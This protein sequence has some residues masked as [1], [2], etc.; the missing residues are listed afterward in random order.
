[1]KS[2]FLTLATP[3][4]V[5]LARAVLLRTAMPSDPSKPSPPLSRADL[6]IEA[7]LVVG[8]IRKPG[9]ALKVME[10]LLSQDEPV[11]LLRPAA[12]PIDEAEVRAEAIVWLREA[13]VRARAR[14]AQ[15]HAL[16]GERRKRRP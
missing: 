3:W 15:R 12:S 14:A 16:K 13:S 6:I 5:T 2:P 4:A 9:Y 8:E 7:M 11:A 1:V 10:Q